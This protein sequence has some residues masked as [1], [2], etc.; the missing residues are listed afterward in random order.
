M[1]SMVSTNDLISHMPITHQ[2][3]FQSKVIN[4][5]R[6]KLPSHMLKLSVNWEF[7]VWA[8]LYRWDYGEMSSVAPKGLENYLTWSVT[9]CT[10]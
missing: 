4:A 6:P 8:R 5:M 9:A 7:E 3:H 10:V 2:P 1:H